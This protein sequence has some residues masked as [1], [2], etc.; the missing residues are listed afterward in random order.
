[1][2]LW[3]VRSDLTLVMVLLSKVEA[4]EVGFLGTVTSGKLL[5]VKERPEQAFGNRDL[6]LRSDIGGEDDAAVGC[7]QTRRKSSGIPYLVRQLSDYLSGKSTR[8][9]PSGRV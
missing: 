3:E 5:K 8:G 9:V 7:H 1:M 6:H 2:K 4:L